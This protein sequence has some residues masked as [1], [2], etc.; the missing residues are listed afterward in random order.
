MLNAEHSA[1]LLNRLSNHADDEHQAKMDAINSPAYLL[2]PTL[3]IDGNQWCALYGNNQQN[4]VS[5]FGDS[6]YEAY[7]D[8]DKEWLKKLDK[9]SK[10]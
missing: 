3:S 9:E 2:K 8:F 4:G 5:G 10:E 7:A 6:P 1:D